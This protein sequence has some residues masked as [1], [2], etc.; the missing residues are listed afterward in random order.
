VSALATSIPSSHRRE[1]EG[2]ALCTLSAASFAGTILLVKLAYDAGAT[3][4]S[5]LAPRFL[6]AAGALWLIAARRGVADIP[7]R[8]ALVGLGLGF[9]VYSIQTGLLLGSLTRIEPSLAELLFFCYPALVVL[10]SLVLSRERPSR[11]RFAA[12]TLASGGVALV[13]VDGAVGPAPSTLGIA[14]PL[15]SAALY[16]T[17]VLAAETLSRRVHPLTLSALLCSGAGTAF[18]AVGLATGRLHVDMPPAA[19]GWTLAIALGTTL[20]SMSALLAGVARVGSSRASILGMLE[21][22]LTIVG[23]YIV[24]GDRLGPLQ[25]V[26]GLLV[27]GAAV[28]V[29]LQ[30]GVRAR[31]DRGEPAG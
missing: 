24:F 9:A 7:R 5:L 18:A 22:P 16:A 12:L 29:Q 30:L 14:M 27:L 13:L 15:G 26:G 31:R 4:I 8:D 3:V 10:G 20:V 28:L 23:A 1:R 17:Y 11:R 19:W 25:I 6:I 21:P 2:V